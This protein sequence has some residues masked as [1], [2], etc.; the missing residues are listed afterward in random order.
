MESSRR[1]LPFDTAVDTPILK[2]NHVIRTFIYYEHISVTFINEEISSLKKRFPLIDF[3]N[4]NLGLQ[5]ICKQG[6]IRHLMT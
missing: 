1:T 5:I 2:T 3:R 4:K 6:S